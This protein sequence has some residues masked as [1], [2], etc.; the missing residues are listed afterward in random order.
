MSI[1]IWLVLGFF[2]AVGIYLFKKWNLRPVNWE[3]EEVSKLLLSWLDDN[4]DDR[5]WD[6]FESCEIANPKL[7]AIRQRALDAV[8]FE[9][10]FIV[11]TRQN[12]LRL[13][14]KG[15]ELFQELREKCLEI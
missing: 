12:G 9:S 8:Y 3:P 14:E 4:I 5:A 7:E 6:Y 10:P 11:S 13:N 15:K 2:L 1:F